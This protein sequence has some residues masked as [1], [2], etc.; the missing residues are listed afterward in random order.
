VIDTLMYIMFDDSTL[1]S[2]P[3]LTGPWRDYML[4]LDRSIGDAARGVV[5]RA[6]RSASS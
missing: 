3:E 6:P 4:G 5:Y 1:A 2:R